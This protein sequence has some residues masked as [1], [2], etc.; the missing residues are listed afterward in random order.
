MTVQFNGAGSIDP[1][2]DSLTYTWDFD[3]SNSVADSTAP[4]TS[5]EYDTPGTYFVTMRVSDS[6]GAT[7]E[8]TIQIDVDDNN[9]IP[10]IESPAYGTVFSL[11]DTLTLKGSASDRED[12]QL[13]QSSLLWNVVLR[14]QVDQDDTYYFPILQSV[15]GSNIDVSLPEELPYGPSYATSSVMVRLTATDSAGI[16]MTTTRMY[17]VI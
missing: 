8:A 12:G 2:G 16:H 10:D 13:S 14:I 1:D 6:G 9:P 4:M 5:Y 17:D 15:A 7:S 11:G 3:D